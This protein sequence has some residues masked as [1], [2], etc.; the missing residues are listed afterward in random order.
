MVRSSRSGGACGLAAGVEVAGVRRGFEA[1]L[2]RQAEIENFQ[3]LSVAATI[4]HK[5]IGR[6]D[7]AMHDAPGVRRSQ[8]TCRLLA[9]GEYLGRG[10]AVV[11]EIQ[12]QRLASQQLH[13]QVGLS[14]LFADVVNGADVGVVQGG[15]CPGLAQKAL[16]GKVDP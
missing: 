13:H 15:G 6:L 2:L 16:M 12:L 10:K 1:L 9:Q 5:Q 14:V 3:L 8:S 4:D 7:I 11:G